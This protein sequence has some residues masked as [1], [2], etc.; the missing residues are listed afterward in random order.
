MILIIRSKH[1]NYTENN[2]NACN[3]SQCKSGKQHN[4]EWLIKKHYVCEITEVCT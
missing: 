3:V 1:V 4:Y 2:K